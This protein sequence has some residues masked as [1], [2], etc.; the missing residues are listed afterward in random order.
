M[1][2]IGCILQVCKLCCKWQSWGIQG[3]SCHRSSSNK[4]GRKRGFTFYE[5]CFCACHFSVCS[6]WDGKSVN[7]LCK[8]IL[9]NDWR[10]K[11][12]QLLSSPLHLWRVTPESAI[13][14]LTMELL[15]RASG[16]QTCC[17]EMVIAHTERY[18]RETKCRSVSA[19][20]YRYWNKG[21]ERTHNT[22][23]KKSKNLHFVVNLLTS[24][25]N[26][27][28]ILIYICGYISLTMKLTKIL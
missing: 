23:R 7:P 18:R 17:T 1:R 3:Q 2:I 13:L 25:D 6:K 21:R 22:M 16:G 5:A 15:A 14:A 10:S 8:V 20:W 19:V 27:F 11:T 12:R 26:C 4:G 24:M 9:I 28:R